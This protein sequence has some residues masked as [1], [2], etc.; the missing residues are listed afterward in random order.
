MKH[1][2]NGEIIFHIGG[3]KLKANFTLT[4]VIAPAENAIAVANTTIAGTVGVPLSGDLGLSGG[5]G[6]GYVVTE[7]D[8]TQLPPGVTIDETGKVG[9]TPSKDGTFTVA[10]GVADSDG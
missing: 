2:A 9:G 6:K 7:V 10:I 5:S 4:F 3:I 8:A 1:H